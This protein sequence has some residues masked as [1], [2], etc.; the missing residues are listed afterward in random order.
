MSELEHIIN[1]GREKL[2]ELT[3]KNSERWL[4]RP[5]RDVTAW[6]L[7][8]ILAEMNLGG[9]REYVEKLP[10]KVGRHFVKDAD[11]RKR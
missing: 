10:E 8:H 5:R 3:Y 9:G 7:A 1:V 6:E 4:F 2:I 11:G